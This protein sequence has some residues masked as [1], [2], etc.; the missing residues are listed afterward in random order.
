MEYRILCHIFS[1]SICSLKSLHTLPR[2]SIYI[3]Q[4]SPY[5]SNSLHIYSSVTIYILQQ[6]PYSPSIL[7]ESVLHGQPSLMLVTMPL[8]GV[9]PPNLVCSIFPLSLCRAVLLSVCLIDGLLTLAPATLRTEN[10]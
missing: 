10:M 8:L 7:W 9:L 1:V 4:Q 6:S 5:T 3:L 2:V